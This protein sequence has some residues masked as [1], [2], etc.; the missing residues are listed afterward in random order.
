MP[1]EHEEQVQE[2]VERLK[3]HPQCQL[4]HFVPARMVFKIRKKN[5]A[6]KEIKVL[7]LHKC[8]KTQGASEGSQDPFQKS[9]SVGLSF[10]NAP[11]DDP[12]PAAPAA[13]DSQE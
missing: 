7:G 3:A 1:A 8:R 10:L 9:L 4:V 2:V 12:A 5:L 13:H 6:S 11:D